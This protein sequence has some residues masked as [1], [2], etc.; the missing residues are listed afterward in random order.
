MCCRWPRG[1]R[2]IF[3]RIP[4]V[5]GDTEKLAFPVYA[6]RLGLDLDRQG[7][8]IIEVGG[9]RN[10]MEFALIAISFGIPTGIV[11]DEDSSDFTAAQKKDEE[12]YNATL[13][14]LAKADGCVKVWRF[15]PV[16]KTT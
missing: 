10:L 9:K 14:A 7:A 11:Y 6:R 1:L 5:E 15:Q 13:D 12:D 3:A 2:E 8:T 4:R 16:T